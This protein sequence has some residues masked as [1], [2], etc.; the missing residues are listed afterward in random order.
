VSQLFDGEP[1]G[2]PAPIPSQQTDNGPSEGHSRSGLG[3][4]ICAR[5]AR[6]QGAQLRLVPT[7]VGTRV[8]LLLPLAADAAA[9]VAT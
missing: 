6:E 1:A 7:K 2:Y 3:L 8:E 4:A 5:L 9:K